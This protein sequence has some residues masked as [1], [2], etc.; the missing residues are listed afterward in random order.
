MKLHNL[1]NSLLYVKYIKKFF[2]VALIMGLIFL[3]SKIQLLNMLKYVYQSEMRV[4]EC[5]IVLI[6]NMYE[7]S[8]LSC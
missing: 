3:L 7:I 6:Y 8:A 5:V 1:G 2:L 4:E